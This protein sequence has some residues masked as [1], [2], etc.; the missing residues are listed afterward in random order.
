MFIKK[1]FFSSIIQIFTNVLNLSF[2][3]LIAYY[4]GATEKMDS[5]AVVSGFLIAFNSL[6]LNSQ[7]NSF[8]PFISKYKNHPQQKEIISSIIQ[9]NILFFFLISL[10]MFIFSKSIVFLLAPGMTSAQLALS[11]SIL[12]ILCLFVL[13]SNMCGVGSALLNYKFQFVQRYFVSMLRSLLVIVA[14]LV[15]VR[16]IGIF[17]APVAHIVALFIVT[18]FHLMLFY[19]NGFFINIKFEFWNHYVKEYVILLLPI[20][21]SGFFVWMIKYADIFV[22]SFLRTGSISHLNYCSKITVN[23]AIIANIIGAV[24]FPIL[25]KLSSPNNQKEYINTF[26]KGLQTIFIIAIGM[27]FFIFFFSYSI[28]ELLFERGLFTSKDTVIVANVLKC[29]IFTVLCAPLGAYFSQVY[30]S[31]RKTKYAMLFSI[32]SSTVNICLNIVLGYL[33]GVI[34]LALASS[35][36]FLLGNI[37]Q[38]TNIKRVNNNFKITHIGKLIYKPT[39]AGLITILIL[40]LT[41]TGFLQLSAVTSVGLKIFRLASFFAL[42]CTSYFLLLLILKVPVIIEV[43]SKLKVYLTRSGNEK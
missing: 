42:F 26:Y 27:T 24:Y 28:I 21:F 8:I 11:S 16:Y 31:Y 7:I 34:G 14:F 3:I 22:A 37:L 4:F 30:F 33:Y 23:S 36:A 6:F 2:G 20:L 29:Y 1:T 5:Y 40:Y 19:K 10:I 25:S 41:L 15:L 17:G 38:L 43:G 35:I 9:T 18:L 12:K 32:I 13:L 39:I